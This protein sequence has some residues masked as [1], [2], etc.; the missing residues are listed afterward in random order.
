[1]LTTFA[2]DVEL[3]V[4]RGR[5]RAST[6]GTFQAVALLVREERARI[7][8]APVS[9]A[10]RSE[11]LKKLDGV[12]TI[13]ARTAARDGTLLTLL[14]DEAGLLPETRSLLREMRLTAGIDS[15]AGQPLADEPEPEAPTVE[16]RVVPQSVVARQ[17]ANPF[18]EPDYSA[19]TT[20]HRPRLLAT[21]ELINPLLRSFEAA[22]GGAPSCMPLPPP[23]T[24]HV[25]G[26][27][28]LMPH[29]AQV[30]AAA[31]AG[32]RTFL[33]ADEPGLGKTAQALL[34][35]DAASA[36][37]LLAV[38]PNVVKTNWAHEAQLWTPA[39][40]ATVVHG[41]GHDVD[42]FSDIV[43]VN[44]DVLHR[45]V[46]WLSTFGFRGM[47]IDEAHFIKNKGAQRSRAVL[48]LS[49]RVRERAGRPLLM[50]LT[51]T[52]LINDIEDFLSIWEFLSWIRGD[53]V[54]SE[55]MAALERNGL[56]PTDPGFSPAARAAVIDLGIVRR[57]KVDVAADI[58]AR[59]IADMP[60]ELEGALGLSI[61]AAEQA[62]ARRLV[63]RYQSALEAR[64]EQ[65]AGIDHAL[66]RKVAGWERQDAKDETDGD[67][68][69]SMMRRIGQAK[70][71]LAADYTAQLAHSAG[72]V[73]FF[74]KHIDVMDVAEQTF[75]QRGLGFS[76]IR[77]GQ[78]AKA[79]KQAIEA[80]Q[81]D[82]DTA[83][84]VCSLS[85]AGVGIN[86]QVASNV[87]LAELSWTNAE[88]TQAI[89]RVHRIGQDQPVT[90]WRIIAAQ[91]I[92][93]R[94][95][96]LIDEKAG[97]AGRALDGSDEA[98]SSVDVQLE[99]LVTLLTDAL[100]ASKPT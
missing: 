94:I 6:R 63:K 69:F 73:V 50:A 59:R 60:V 46:G 84:I 11:Q 23:T 37:P 31:A 57:R 45:H 90:A 12:A 19:T 71:G 70:A 66:V 96:E 83:V 39:R 81:N 41:D 56:V 1:M 61:R 32:H 89:D 67:N 99:A 48:E 7:Q 97:L 68:V 40:S 27:R 58:P 5:I 82:P 74:A 35:A 47:V 54:G 14:S 44:Y 34:A 26:G 51:G 43:V 78:T 72:K 85:A 17:L 24:L 16:R 62:L 93:A 38:V 21:W 53:E 49:K 87:V 10:R 13:L 55:L 20:T 30:V 92:D 80:F 98:T 79:R 2:R 42:A 95:A 22:S 77:G 36:F 25:R 9:E 4:Q 76:S 65:V 28:D 8:S 91:T 86:L 33:L 52:P 3:A 75:Q 64:G 18:L 15:P 88:Q 29:Q 100:A